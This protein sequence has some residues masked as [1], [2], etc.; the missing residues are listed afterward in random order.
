MNYVD[1]LAHFRI[2]TLDSL[3]VKLDLTLLYELRHAPFKLNFSNF[4][5]ISCNIFSTRGDGLKI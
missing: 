5:L 1:R 4:I 3:R 2:G